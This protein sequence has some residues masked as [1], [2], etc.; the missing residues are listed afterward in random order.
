MATS[1][2]LELSIFSA[3]RSRY[4]KDLVIMRPTVFY[5]LALPVVDSCGS[6]WVHPREVGRK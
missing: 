3:P 6:K 1:R 5:R 2:N 4:S